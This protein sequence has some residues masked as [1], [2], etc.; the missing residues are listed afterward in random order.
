MKLI[1]KNNKKLNGFH[2]YNDQLFVHGM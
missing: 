1:L 2:Y